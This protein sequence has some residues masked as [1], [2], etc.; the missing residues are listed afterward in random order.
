M[1]PARLLM[2]QVTNVS[3]DQCSGRVDTEWVAVNF[4]YLF[5]MSDDSF[6]LLAESL[7]IDP[8]PPSVDALIREIDRELAE[9]QIPDLNPH[10]HE[11]QIALIV[12]RQSLDARP[13]KPSTE[14]VQLSM[15]TA[16]EKLVAAVVESKQSTEPAPAPRPDPVD[17]MRTNVK[18]T[19]VR[20]TTDFRR[21]RTLP[22]AGLGSLIAAVW[23]ARSV[24][25]VGAPEIPAQ[26]FYT[27]GGAFVILGIYTYVLLWFI[28]HRADGVLRR[29]Y[30]PD[31]QEEALEG[32]T[33]VSYGPFVHN[34]LERHRQDGNEERSSSPFTRTNY[35]HSLAD[36]SG[37]R[38]LR[39]S[40]FNLSPLRL[41]TVDL[42]SALVDAAG[43]ALDRL[44]DIGI[45][46]GLVLDGRHVY[47]RA[48]TVSGR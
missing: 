10:Q 27:T 43:L 11:R 28:Q 20:A 2:G 30:D 18:A 6:V 47:R 41:S 33:R 7:G 44:I 3:V 29:F 38:R 39:P 21:G 16:I 45:V 19:E 42:E 34:D 24:F 23:A 32:V 1:V 25:G 4:R 35:R 46:E 48:G 5:P 15:M 13:Q 31:V 14:L 37:Y 12:A 8:E 22:F 17:V 40:V 26:V 9:L 36:R